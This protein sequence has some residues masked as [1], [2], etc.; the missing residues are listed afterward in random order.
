MEG[1][2]E[3]GK[4]VLREC[5]WKCGV[6]GEEDRAKGGNKKLT[7]LPSC[8]TLSRFSLVSNGSLHRDKMSDI[9]GWMRKN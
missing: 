3:V 2:W 6:L 5:L 7:G 9:S 8:P 4:K 1:Q